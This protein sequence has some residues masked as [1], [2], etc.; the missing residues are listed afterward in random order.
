MLFKKVSIIKLLF[1]SADKIEHIVAE[2]DNRE[3]L[4][5]AMMKYIE[6]ELHFKSYYTRHWKKENREYIDYGSH[7][8]YFIIEY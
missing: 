7:A 4:C 2:S 8:N 1:Q 5:E 3:E 6:N